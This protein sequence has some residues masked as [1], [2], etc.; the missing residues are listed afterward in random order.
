MSKTLRDLR[1]KLTRHSMRTVL[2]PFTRMKDTA[3]RSELHRISNTMQ[4]RNSDPYASA[5]CGRTEEFQRPAVAFTTRWQRVAEAIRQHEARNLL[6][7]GC[8]EG[9]MIRR[10]ADE[11][12]VFAVGLEMDWRRIRTGLAERDLGGEYRHGIVP[13]HVSPESLLSL[14]TFDVVICFSVLHH[15]IRLHGLDEGRSFLSSLARITGKCFLFD[16]GSP[17]ET[18]F[19]PEWGKILAFLEG[20]VAGKTAELLRT[21]GFRDVTHIDDTPGYVESGIRPLFL[22]RPPDV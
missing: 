8:A 17:E 18:A 1:R 15:V 2:Y 16:M 10:A 14:P 20:D 3:I 12:G 4:V 19:N 7:V 22:C 13:M 11:C 6:D 21:A 5:C 9:Y